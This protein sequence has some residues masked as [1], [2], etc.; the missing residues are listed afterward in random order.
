M[1]EL[2]DIFADDWG[3][4][5]RSGVVAVVGRPNVGKSS[6]LNALLGQ[7]IAITTPKPQTTRRQQL[8]ILT[9]PHAQILFTDTPG[10]HRPHNKLG[11][12]MVAAA[13]NALRD[14]DVILW[15]MDA[16]E[17]PNASDRLISEK[18]AK[19]RQT[20]VLLILNK[21]DL[22]KG[23]VDFSAHIA[24]APEA[25]LLHVSALKG[26]N[27]DKLIEELVALLPLGPRYYPVDQVS[28]MN[29]R[30]I[31]AE[32]IR[33]KIINNTSQEVPHS[34]AVEIDGFKEEP[35][36][37]TIS[38]IIYVEKDSQRGILV[39]K[40]GSMIKKIGTEARREL[41][42]QM[43]TPV[44]LDLRVKVLPNWRDDEALMRRMGYRLPTDDD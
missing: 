44:H 16:T 41:I 3:D 7:K 17:P 29:M 35:D 20:P 42:E 9:L 2:D 14:A 18:L 30:F 38:A 31:A 40:G 6:L 11:E 22:L 19:I 1:S 10:I 43:G 36:R 23:V 26:T 4:D 33:E 37:S 32:I 5:H 12:Y 25:K 28:D 13:E 39:G 24:L 34:V 8:G 27:I 15:I 21:V